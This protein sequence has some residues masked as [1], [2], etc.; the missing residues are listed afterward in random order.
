MEFE[1]ID[2]EKDRMTVGFERSKVMLFMRIIRVAKVV[3]DSDCL[4]DARDS[5]GAECGDAASH[6]GC[7][8]AE[9]LTQSIIQVANAL[10][11]GGLD[12]GRHGRLR[13][14]L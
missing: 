8:F 2:L 1:I 11:L 12:L 9:V 5:L 7:A 3:I 4:N 13:C 6:H 10:G 14:D